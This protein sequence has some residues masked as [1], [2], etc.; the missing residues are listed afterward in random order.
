MTIISTLS[1][2]LIRPIMNVCTR[3]A[4]LSQGHV[5]LSEWFVSHVIRHMTGS[6]HI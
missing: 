4:G 6:Y 2:R 1:P 5:P 3:M